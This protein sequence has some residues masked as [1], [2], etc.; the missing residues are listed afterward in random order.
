MLAWRGRRC[1]CRVV[2][3][4]GDLADNGREN[5]MIVMPECTV[6]MIGMCVLMMMNVSD[7]EPT[8]SDPVCPAVRVG[9]SVGISID[10]SQSVQ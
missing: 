7:E 3:G 10:D 2:D 6:G 8:S 1:K 9:N 4:S 5:D